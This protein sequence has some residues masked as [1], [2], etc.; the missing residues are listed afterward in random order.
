LV[1]VGDAKNS[2]S[3]SIKSF[4]AGKVSLW[5]MLRLWLAANHP[6]VYPLEIM[7]ELASDRVRVRSLA[8]EQT[9]RRQKTS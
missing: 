1:K 2:R 8:A 3:E 4:D 6:F 5:D 7:S 9:G